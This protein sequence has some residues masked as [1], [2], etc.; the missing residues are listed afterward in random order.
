M[1]NKKSQP[2]KR[3]Q[4]LTRREENL[5]AGDSLEVRG[6]AMV[7]MNADLEN[8]VNVRRL[9]SVHTIVGNAYATIANEIQRLALRSE[10]TPLS[11]TETRTFEKMTMSLARLVGVEQDIKEESKLSGLSDEELKTLADTAMDRLAGKKG[12]AP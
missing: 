4:L 7:N 12:R 3:V 8:R 1:E 5:E 9:P 11:S 6:A 10:R 2:R